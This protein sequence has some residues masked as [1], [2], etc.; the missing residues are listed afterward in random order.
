MA[1]ER[2]MTSPIG[3]SFF[4]G[5]TAAGTADDIAAMYGWPEIHLDFLIFPNILLFLFGRV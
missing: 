4:Q 1:E 5:L 3:A 2:I